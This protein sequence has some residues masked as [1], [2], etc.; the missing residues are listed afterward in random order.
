MYTDVYSVAPAGIFVPADSKIETP[1]DLAGVP[2]SVGY[3][4]GSHYATVQALEAYLKP[5]QINLNYADGMLFARMERLIDG[6]APAVNLFSGPY[7][8]A[9]QLGFRKVIDTT[10]MIATMIHG[11]PDAE[12][13]RKFFRALRKAQ[14][15]IDLR[16][17]RYTHYYRNEF[18][19]R[20]HAAMDTRR[21]GP[22]ERLVF[23]PYTKEV[24]EQSFAWIADR[25]IF[26]EGAMGT[27][28]YE[29]ATL[30]LIG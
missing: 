14:R 25:H 24:Y 20:F 7:Y 16:P 9:E 5:E 4:S 2:V 26:P 29:Q 11:D 22:G 18:P 3:Q 15:D 17:E 1:A 12:D 6:T 30:S 21:W 23:E 8:F 10:F 27:G 13:L 28:R 19:D